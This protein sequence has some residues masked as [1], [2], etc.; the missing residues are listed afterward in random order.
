MDEQVFEEKRLVDGGSG[1]DH[2]TGLGAGVEGGDGG[3]GTGDQGVAV[4][5]LEGG[6]DLGE[7]VGTGPAGRP[8]LALL[9]VAAE[10][11]G[12]AV[13]IAGL[14]Q[15]FLQSLRFRLLVAFQSGQGVGQDGLERF[16]AEGGR[17]PRSVERA[18]DFQRRGPQCR[19]PDA[20][21][22]GCRAGQ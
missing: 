17:S 10:A 20:R 18:G 14:G 1:D 8:G 4:D 16:S 5:P 19:Q 21:R 9:E 22:P 6:H 11:A 7:G 3:A 2:L 13:G 12:E 15:L